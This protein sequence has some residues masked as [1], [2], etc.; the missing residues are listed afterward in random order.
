LH[1]R[2]NHLGG[3]VGVHGWRRPPGAP[4]GAVLREMGWVK[5]KLRRRKGSGG[6]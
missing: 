4:P 5:S 3:L 6:A 2:E 1:P